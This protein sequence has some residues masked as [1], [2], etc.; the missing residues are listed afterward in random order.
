MIQE[1]GL[2]FFPLCVAVSVHKR[3]LEDR[4]HR[5]LGWNDFWAF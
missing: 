5:H 1:R 2:L 4:D 3:R